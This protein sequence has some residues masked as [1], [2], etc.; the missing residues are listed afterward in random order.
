MKKL[1]QISGVMGLVAIL[2]VSTVLNAQPMFHT[3]PTISSGGNSIPLSYSSGCRGQQVYPVGVFG[4]PPSGQAITTIYFMPGTSYTGTRTYSQFHVSLK[5]A[6]ISSLSTT[7]ETGM[8]NVFS[9][10]N[11]SISYVG[12][13]WFAITL[14]KPF[15][16]NPSLPLIW[17]INVQSSGGS[18]FF[19]LNKGS[20]VTG[21]YRN[22]STSYNASVAAGSGAYMLDMGFDLGS[23]GYP[24]S[25]TIGKVCSPAS[26]TC[27]NIPTV[28]S[29]TILNKGKA[30]LDSV[31]MGARIHYQ[32]G[33]IR[34]TAFVPE[35]NWKGFLASGEESKCQ[36]FFNWSNGFR[37]GDSV[38]LWTRLPNG[39][40][41]SAWQD[42]TILY[43]IKPSM[44]S[45]LYTIG[46]T[47]H[48]F[49]DLKSAFST[50][51]D[52][53][54]GVCDTV[55]FELDSSS[56]GSF[57]YFGQYDICDVAGTS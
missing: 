27:G 46:D 8:T 25:A 21:A 23:S 9:S 57:Q 56:K 37:T 44:A 19:C 39:I 38:Y 40:V 18:T 7:Y 24:N 48:D 26:P 30:P 50:L 52:T 16:Y 1:L 43:V 20:S 12:G 45:G 10:T 55:I 32:L 47:L 13:Q 33:A 31:K 4:T 29:A 28:L 2:S 6:N 17:E 35:F 11:Y 36:T 14:Q 3:N 22:Y 5:Q 51:C 42:D 54:G 34:D 41:D 53:F 49:V 15:P